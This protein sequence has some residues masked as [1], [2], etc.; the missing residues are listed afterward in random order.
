MKIKKTFVVSTET[1]R[2]RGKI[3]FYIAEVIPNKGLRLIDNDFKCSSTSNKG[4][5]TE[6][7]NRLVELKELPE[8]VLDK[9]G[10]INPKKQHPFILIHFQGTELGLIYVNQII[11]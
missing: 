6:A 5:E 7:V 9:A 4:I 10:Y 1:K 8:K 3:S 2:V 11:S